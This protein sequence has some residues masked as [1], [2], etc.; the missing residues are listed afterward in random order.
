MAIELAPL[1]GR[2]HGLEGWLAR[3]W[4]SV[5]PGRVDIETAGPSVIEKQKKRK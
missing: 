2:K 3:D 5:Y 4:A 1:K